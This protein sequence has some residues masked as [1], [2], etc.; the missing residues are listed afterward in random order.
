MARLATHDKGERDSGVTR[1]VLSLKEALALNKIVVRRY[2]ASELDNTAFAKTINEDPKERALFR[3]DLN[4]GHIKSA[5]EGADIPPNRSNSRTAF[6]SD[7]E[8]IL[9]I[10]TLE[11]QVAALMRELGVR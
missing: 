11:T 2:A 3:F 1:G 7:V 4:P 6:R 9:R 5:I 8:L 10:Q